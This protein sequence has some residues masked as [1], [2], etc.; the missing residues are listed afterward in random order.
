[1]PGSSGYGGHMLW[2]LRGERV[3]VIFQ[4]MVW[5]AFLMTRGEKF[6]TAG[7]KPFFYG[8]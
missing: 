5:S 1:M 8:S 3:K 6:L 7:G 2:E 4:L